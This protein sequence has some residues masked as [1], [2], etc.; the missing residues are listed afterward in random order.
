MYSATAMKQTKT[1]TGRT[2]RGQKIMIKVTKP[3]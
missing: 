3:F 1:K 2:F